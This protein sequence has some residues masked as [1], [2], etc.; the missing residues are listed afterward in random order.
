MAFKKT[1][2]ARRPRGRP[3]A[4]VRR[5]WVT[6]I[7]ASWCNPYLF[8]LATC[9]DGRSATSVIFQIVNQT[10]LQDE[11]SDSA[12]VKRVVGDLFF[13]PFFNNG[14]STFPDL[15]QSSSALHSYQAFAGLRKRTV[16]AAG[17]TTSVSPLDEDEDYGD[18]RWL[19]T[20]H[21]VNYPA[22]S[23]EASISTFNGQFPVKD[24]DVHTYLTGVPGVPACSTLAGGS[25]SICIETTG[26]IDCVNCDSTG[27]GAVTA[28][29]NPRPWTFHMDIKRKRGMYLKENEELVLQ[30]DFAFPF[31]NTWLAN[32]PQMHVFGGIKALLQY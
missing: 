26:D 15:V 7:R 20:W 29:V 5:S 31:L 19:R 25:G 24:I 17:Q 3:F 22:A 28:V 6:N 14:P 13:L 23:V 10:M 9:N 18:A 32:E 21:H 11:F 16:N 4:R 27:T 8:E 2:R 12:A 1:F 30:V